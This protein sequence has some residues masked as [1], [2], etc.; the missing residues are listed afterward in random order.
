VPPA[1]LSK[2]AGELR[3]RVRDLIADGG[4]AFY[5][6]TTEAFDSVR[7]QKA[8]DRINAVVLLTD[9]EDT[10]SQQTVDDVIAHLKGQGDSENRV[11]VFTIAYSS[12]ASGSRDQLKRIAEASGGL[13]YEGKTEHIESVYRS[14]S[15]F[16]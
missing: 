12:G 6:A 11:R 7:A 15:S 4:T 14:I 8:T 13:S 1:P 10:D 2:N 3:S 9:G 16:F 5:D